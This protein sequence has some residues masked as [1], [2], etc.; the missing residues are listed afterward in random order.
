MQLARKQQCSVR[1]PEKNLCEGH[2]APRGTSCTKLG[3]WVESGGSLPI[4]AFAH[5]KFTANLRPLIDFLMPIYNLDL[6]LEVSFL[7]LFFQEY[8]NISEINYMTAS[9]QF[10]ND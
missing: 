4:S 1:H 3:T 10:G 9:Y 8:S 2:C 6:D 5:K 7:F